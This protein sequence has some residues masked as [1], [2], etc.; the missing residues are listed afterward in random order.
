MKDI[1]EEWR[2]YENEEIL[3]RPVQREDAKSLLKVYSDEKARQFFNCDNFETPCYFDTLE[4]MQAE[5]EFY[6]DSYKNRWFVRW[7]IVEKKS[8][9][10]VGTIELFQRIARDE[11]TGERRD[12]FDGRGILR[13]DI[14]SDWENTDFIKSLFSL[15][16][17]RGY[18]DFGVQV[19]ATKIPPQ[20]VARAKAAQECGFEKS[21]ETIGANLGGQQYGDY[22]IRENAT[23]GC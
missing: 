13:M 3:L 17:Q 4:Q 7:S 5:L 19:I 16:L 8:T 23:G 1:Y 21:D 20:A 15:V 12:A 10:V 22:W 9:E 14:R 6:L 18:R 2:S 11:K